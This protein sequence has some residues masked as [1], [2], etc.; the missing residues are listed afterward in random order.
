[1]NVAEDMEEAD[2]LSITVVTK[3]NKIKTIKI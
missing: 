3:Q 1:M 2:V